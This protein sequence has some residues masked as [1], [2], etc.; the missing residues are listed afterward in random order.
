MRTLAEIRARSWAL[1]SAE[2]VERHVYL[3][4]GAALE[5]MRAETRRLRGELIT[6]VTRDLVNGRYR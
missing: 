3:P 4:V 6:S 1:M 2:E 5:E